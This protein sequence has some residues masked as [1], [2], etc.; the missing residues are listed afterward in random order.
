MRAYLELIRLPNLFT[1]MADV[2]M[3][4]F[5]VAS[6]QRI[7][8]GAV[9]G[10]LLGAS[11]LLYAA[12]VALNDVMDLDV[13]RAGRPERP[14]P[15]GRIGRPAAVRLVCGL[16]AGGVIL[17]AAAAAAGG[18][19][20]TLVGALALAAAVVVYDVLLKRTPLGP[21]AMGVCRAFNVLLGMSIGE[22][23]WT[24]AHGLVAGGL[25]VY[26]AGVTWLARHEAQTSRRGSLILAVG[27]M[28]LG[29]GLLA[30]LPSWCEVAGQAD[31]W[32]VLMAVLGVLAAWRCRLAILDPSPRHVQMAVRQSIL[33]IV[34]LD[35][36]V[37]LAL[38]GPGPAVAVLG[39]L[40]PAVALGQWIR[41]T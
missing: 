2:A 21:P 22:A 29:I 31:A 9:L 39:L 32:Q 33:A 6:L 10:L 26:V 13:D 15:S 37:C 35:A 25:G 3:G 17:G 18:S 23:A 8:D 16:L 11:A 20:R 12:G 4:F 28:L 19:A 38:A 1:A 7:E 41:L 36:A 30:W 24:G 34:V 5:A 27:I 40:V 14:L